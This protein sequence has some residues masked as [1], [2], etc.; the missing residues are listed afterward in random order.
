MQRIIF[1]SLGV[2]NLPRKG[3][4]KEAREEKTLVC[5]LKKKGPREDAEFLISQRPEKGNYYGTEP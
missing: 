5:I 1:Y 4:K 3:R 2:Q